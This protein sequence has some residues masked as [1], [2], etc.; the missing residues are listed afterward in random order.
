M[1]Q[2]LEFESIF[3]GQML[4]FSGFSDART[5]NIGFGGEA[6]SAMLLQEYAHKIVESGGFGLAE[7][8][9]KQL[10]EDRGSNENLSSA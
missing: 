6:F 2:A 3:V 9:Y 10:V 5:Q 4:K 7:Q 8:I 1:D